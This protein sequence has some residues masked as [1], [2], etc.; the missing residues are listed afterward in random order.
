MPLRNSALR[1]TSLISTMRLSSILRK[2]EEQLAKNADFKPHYTEP[3]MEK[4]IFTCC[5]SGQ[6]ALSSDEDA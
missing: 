1:L 2:L 6:K 3:Q 4:P 5:V